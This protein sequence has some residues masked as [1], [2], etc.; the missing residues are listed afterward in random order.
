M[1]A[2][3]ERTISWRPLRSARTNSPT[4]VRA[5]PTPNFRATPRIINPPGP[6]PFVAAAEKLG[7]IATRV[8]VGTGDNQLIGGF[9]VTG[10]QPKKVIVRAIGPSLNQFGIGTALADPT[11]ELH[12]QTGAVIADER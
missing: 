2:L 6:P 12:D 8:S 4:S 5:C 1:W 9:I 10:N 3:R 7:N 11:L